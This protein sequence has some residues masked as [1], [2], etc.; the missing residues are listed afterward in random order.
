MSRADGG[1]AIEDWDFLEQVNL[2]KSENMRKTL[3]MT[4]TIPQNLTANT[5]KAPS[6]DIS[7]KLFANPTIY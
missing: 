1:G 6:R 5:D 2:R 7:N 4:D 3:S